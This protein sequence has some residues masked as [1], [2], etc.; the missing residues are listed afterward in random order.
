MMSSRFF[1]FSLCS[2]WMVGIGLRFIIDGF[3]NHGTYM[4][5]LSDVIFDWGILFILG[6]GLFIFL[7]FDMYKDM[8]DEMDG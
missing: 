4:V 2:A 8:E 5:N 6:I 1:L 7:L 3:I